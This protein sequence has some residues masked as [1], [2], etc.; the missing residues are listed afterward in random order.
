VPIDGGG[1]EGLIWL[2]VVVVLVLAIA[3][4]VS[5][6]DRTEGLAY[7]PGGALDIWIGRTD[8]GGARTANWLPAPR[9][10]P[11]ALTLRAYL[12]RPALLNGAYKLPPIVPA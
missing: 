7:E 1:N 5:I 11:F 9:Q 4:L 6:G 2:N 8:P 10:G 3:A 12:P